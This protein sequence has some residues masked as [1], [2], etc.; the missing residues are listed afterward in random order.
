MHLWKIQ[1]H[2][3]T[4]NIYHKRKCTKYP[5]YSTGIV[6]VWHFNG[7]NKSLCGFQYSDCIQDDHRKIHKIAF[8]LLKLRFNETKFYDRDKKW[9][10]VNKYIGHYRN[11]DILKYT[12]Q[13]LNI[14][15]ENM[16]RE[17][18]RCFSSSF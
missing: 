13:F 1:R 14:L 16:K 3:N 8:N 15:Q 18:K 10:V 5:E 17:Y 12:L 11:V 6:L 4:P 9:I 7:R 2:K